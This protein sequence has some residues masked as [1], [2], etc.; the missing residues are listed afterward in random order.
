MAGFKID[1]F[2]GKAPKVSGRLLPQDMAQTA[3]NVKLESG[4]LRPW[5][6]NHSQSS[7]F[8]A[9]TQSLFKYSSSHWFSST[10]DV[11]Y[12][13]SPI[14]EDP[15]GRVY[16]T[17]ETYPKMANAT[18]AVSGSGT[19]PGSSF[20]LGLIKPAKPTPVVSGTANEGAE[21]ISLAYVVTWVS[22][23]G[24]ESVPSDVTT[25]DI[26]T[27]KAGQTKTITFP[28]QPTGSYALTDAKWR[29]YRTNINGEFQHLIDAAFGT[30]S[31]VDAIED[32]NLG[33]LLQTSDWDA[34]PDEVTADHPDGQLKG[35]VALPNGIF[36]GFSGQTVCISE[37]FMPHAFPKSYQLTTKD[38]IVALA[39]I[40][41]GLLVTT[42]NKP[43]LITGSDS[44]SMS[45]IEMDSNQSCVSKRSMVDMGDYAIYA[46]PDGLIMAGSQGIQVITESVITRDQW[47]ALVPST[48]SGYFYEGR[49]VG[50][51]N[52]GSNQKGFVFDPRGGK[53]ALTDLDFYAHAG[54]ND[55]EA[56]KLYLLISGTLYEFNASTNLRTYTWKSKKFYF[57]RPISPAV[58]KV[59]ADSY[60][61]NI[62]FKLYADGALK[63]TQ[64][65]G[66]SNMFRLPSGYR[67]KQIEVQLEGTQDVNHV[68]VY[69]SPQEV[70]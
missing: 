17:G 33:E 29:L 50:F 64:A 3:N 48:I 32:S 6:D 14:A 11:D 41:N 59:D 49:Y 34:P 30:T 52:D 36:A 12:L 51:Y 68:C 57:D 7:T 5:K 38:D 47:Q 63:H 4:Q 25:A 28:S 1:V 45:M 70:V 15:H 42:K 22:T 16:W 58:A 62:T 65:V 20:R 10:S 27:F 46:S 8:S 37:P 2:S 56:D 23:Y 55:K 66:S 53:N 39:A 18:T 31:Y 61:S 21:D 67:A 9:S 19:Y 26:V 54:F 24:E 35:L 69:E 40:G 44:A 60:S 43:C 13:R